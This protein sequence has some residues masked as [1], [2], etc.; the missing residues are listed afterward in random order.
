MST[1]VCW[2]KWR[3]ACYNGGEYTEQEM[4]GL[5][6]CESAGILVR[7]NPEYISLALDYFPDDGQH[8]KSWRRIMNIPKV[9]IIKERRFEVRRT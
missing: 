7:E 5:A 4:G 1:V 3:D 6:Q 8:I 9:N 2:V